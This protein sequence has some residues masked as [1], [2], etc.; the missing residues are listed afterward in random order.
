VVQDQTNFEKINQQLNQIVKNQ[1]NQNPNYMQQQQT[2]AAQD[3]APA[4][5]APMN[6]SNMQILQQRNQV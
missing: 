4:A 2:I 5:A 6:Q 1:I 3:Q